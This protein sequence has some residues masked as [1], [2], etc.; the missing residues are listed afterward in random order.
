MLGAPAPVMSPRTERAYLGWIR[1][2]LGA[3][4]WRPP[5]EMGET[6]V[7]AFLSDLAVRRKVSAST[8]NQALA[9]LLFLY[10]EVLGVD[11][12]WLDGLVRAGKPRRL[13][14]VL[15]H[16]E[17]G[18]VLA[19]LDGA[20]LLMASLLYGSG[21]RLLECARLRVKDVD[22]ERLEITVREGKG[23]RDR[24][25]TLPISVAPAL[26]RHIEQLHTLHRR[27]L[28]AQ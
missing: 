28:M 4:G 13:P 5:R 2:F 6:K 10:R 26:E 18:D 27:D 19:Q 23:R 20:P 11:L 12:P 24:F 1:R 14:V 17:V 22:L 25:T 15:T 7:T 21:L 3:H 9:A 8:Q 16:A